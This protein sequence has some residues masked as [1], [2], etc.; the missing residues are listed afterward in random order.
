MIL[1]ILAT[2]VFA[3]QDGI[4]RHLAESYNVLT[5]VMF[6]YWFFALCVVSLTQYNGNGCEFVWTRQHV[7]QMGRSVILFAQICCG[8]GLHSVDLVEYQAAL[9]SHHLTITVLSIL[10]LDEWV[11]WRRWTAIEIRLCA[12]IIANQPGTGFFGSAYDT[13]CSRQTV[14]YCLWGFDSLCRA[15]RD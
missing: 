6:R 1:I 8:L 13:A 4:S 9:T 5:I 7:F 10:V 2:M 15:T 12:V 3:I 11:G 14:F